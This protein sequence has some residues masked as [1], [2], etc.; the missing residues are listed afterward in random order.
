MMLIGP[1]L[2]TANSIDDTK[3]FI[4]PIS[5]ARKVERFLSDKAPIF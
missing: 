1:W 2:A 3:Y 5:E 4:R